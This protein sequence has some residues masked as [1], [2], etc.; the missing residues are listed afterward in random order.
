MA[1]SEPVQELFVIV[2]KY[3]QLVL[4]TAYVHQELR[5]FVPDVKRF[6]YQ[7]HAK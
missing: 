5:I 6:I 3:F 2:R 4:V 1:L 7:K